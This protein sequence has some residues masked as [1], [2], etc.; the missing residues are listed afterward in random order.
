[1]QVQRE[2]P[3]KKFK[4]CYEVDWKIRNTSLKY[5]RPFKFHKNE[6]ETVLESGDTC[7]KAFE[8]FDRHKIL[9]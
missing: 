8:S 4:A 5:G 3:D 2:S 6:E 1:M 7:F 9:E